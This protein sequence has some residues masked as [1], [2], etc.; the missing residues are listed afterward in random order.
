MI[1][2]TIL[3]DWNLRS[4]GHCCGLILLLL[5]DQREDVESI[6]YLKRIESAFTVRVALTE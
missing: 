3:S 2:E 6:K 1:K 5:D 4:D